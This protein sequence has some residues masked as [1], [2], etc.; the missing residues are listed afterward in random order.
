[1]CSNKNNAELK[2]WVIS[3]EREVK[4]YET[5]NKKLA[6][7]LEESVKENDELYKKYEKASKNKDY[8]TI[9]SE[10]DK[11]ENLLESKDRAVKALQI[12]YKDEIDR[13]SAKND[14]YKHEIDLL[15]ETLTKKK[16]EVSQLTM[17]RRRAGQMEE[18]EKANIDLNTIVDQLK[19]EVKEKDRLIKKREI[20]ISN[21]EV[22]LSHRNEEVKRLKDKIVEVE[23]EVEKYKNV[24]T[25]LQSKVED[26]QTELW[27]AEEELEERKRLLEYAERINFNEHNHEGLNFDLSERIKALEEQN[28][29]LKSNHDHTNLKDLEKLETKLEEL[30]NEKK[31]LIRTNQKSK[32]KYDR[33]EKERE[34]KVLAIEKIKLLQK[35]IK[36][37]KIEKKKLSDQL[38]RSY[39]EISYLKNF[40]RENKSLKKEKTEL[41]EEI[42]QL[43]RENHKLSTKIMKTYEKSQYGGG[44]FQGDSD[45]ESPA[46][47]NHNYENS[48]DCDESGFLISNSQ[49]MM[50]PTGHKKNISLA[51][52]LNNSKLNETTISVDRSMNRFHKKILV[53]K[54]K[55]IE[56][57]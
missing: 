34:A 24:K 10:N 48:L 19:S 32:A 55:E 7:N 56:E 11:L 36:I 40:E 20:Q 18:V 27:R 12:Q 51:K 17:F 33:I 2:D 53:E 22:N 8:E 37:E 3:L 29:E 50:M 42:R 1:M 15:K 57:K 13:F 43:N 6:N 49:S 23:S 35:E 26:L 41:L 52:Y 30:E 39:N 31:E 45:F 44:D 47:E 28:E 25:D 46:Q 38:F 4:R 14:E 5:E 16:A 9:K 21:L 54:D